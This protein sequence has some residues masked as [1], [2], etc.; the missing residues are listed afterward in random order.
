MIGRRTGGRAAAA[1]PGPADYCARTARTSVGVRMV[2]PAGGA[3]DP[4]KSPA[5]NAYKM[6]DASRG[7][8]PR[9]LGRWADRDA[10]CAYPGPGQYDAPHA[11]VYLPGASRVGRSMAGRPADVKKRDACDPGPADYDGG[12]RVNCCK[13]DRAAAEDCLKQPC[14]VTFGVRRPDAVG[15]F[16]VPRDNEYGCR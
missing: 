13:R 16:A 10:K 4:W 1:T 14:R 11:D 15:V 7:P 3:R 2:R 12:A 8:R 9:M 6:P 5:P